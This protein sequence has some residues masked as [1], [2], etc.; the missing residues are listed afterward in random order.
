MA[1]KSTIFKVALNVA[2]LDRHYYADH[3]FTL[4]RHPSETDERMMVRVVA[5]ALNASEY[6]KFGSGLS[7]VELPDLY[8][9][10]LTG[11]RQVWIEVG[12]PDERAILKAC[13]KARQVKVY[14]YSSSVNLWWPPLAKGLQRAR[15]V[16]VY[17]FSAGAGS[18]L[19]KLAARNMQLQCTIQDGNVLLSAMNVVEAEPVSLELVRLNG[20]G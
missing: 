19:A 4:A 11:A 18:A 13:G 20:E 17:A 6:L 8:E 7:D 3:A 9:D 2:D 1:L 10:D 12:Q 16:E 15:N 14:A 5:F